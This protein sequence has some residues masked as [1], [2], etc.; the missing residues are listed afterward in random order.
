MDAEERLSLE[1]VSAPTLMSAQHLHRYALA[2][3]LCRD[4]RVVD[5]ACGVGYGSEQ[6]SRGG[7]RS[8]VDHRG[9]FG[10]AFT[11]DPEHPPHVAAPR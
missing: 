2:A 4:L 10:V 9:G 11:D 1:A 6:L 3:R 8:V 5:L 7:A